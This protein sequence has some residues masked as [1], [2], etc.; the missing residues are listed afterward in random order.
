MRLRT[1]IENQESENEEFTGVDVSDNGGVL[2]I[3][4]DGYGNNLPV[5]A[6]EVCKGVARVLVFADKGK[7]EPTHIISL[8]DAKK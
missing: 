3:K 5:V 4:I 6:V 8:E 7:D 2:D 1:F